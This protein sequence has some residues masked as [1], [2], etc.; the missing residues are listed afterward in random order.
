MHLVDTTLFYSPTSGG[1]RRYLNAKHDWYAQRRDHQHSLLVP[2]PRSELLRGEVS[3]IAGAIVPGTFNY[4]LPLTPRRWSSMLEALEP[5]VLEAGD[6]FHPAWSTLKVAQRLRIPAVAFFHSHLARLVGIR[7]GALIGRG[8]SKYLSALYERFDL[9]FAPSLVM[10]DYLRS[11]GLKRVVQQPLG[12][13]TAVF[14]PARR[15]LQL[16][17]SL[18]LRQ[19]V[20]LL[21]FAGRFSAEKNIGVLH[22]AFAR[23][24]PGYHLLL[25]GGGEEKRPAPNITVL[26]Y[27]RDSI[28][29]ARMMASADAL[30]H[31]GTAETFGLVAIEAMACGRPVV[32]VR[33]GAIT[34]LVDDSVGVTAERASGALMAQAV[35]DLYD[36]DIDALGR[37][38]RARVEAQYS[39][40]TALREQLAVYASLSEK[41]R[42]LPE[43]W[44]TASLRPSTD[45]ATSPAGPSSSWISSAARLPGP[46]RHNATRQSRPAETS[47]G[48]FG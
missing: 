3:T 29:L 28:E 43:G 14:H 7:C 45:Q 26:P 48:P 25:I 24:G 35:R 8:A 31:A 5:D 44:A 2:G 41:K 13:D 11:L 22:D 4:R 23:L 21:A 34:E 40:D 20:R 32:G 1:V 39:W 18:G 6:A 30:V 10:C 38:A 42:T 27:R 9:V 33:A 17:E 46:G 37:A 47:S 16:R 12:V 15:H 19:D 36:R